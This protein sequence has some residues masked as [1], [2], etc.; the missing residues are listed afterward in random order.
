LFLFPP[1]FDEGGRTAL[2]LCDDEEAR[3]VLKRAYSDQKQL[4][5][6]RWGITGFFWS[7]F[8][9]FLVFFKKQLMVE[10]WGI[11]AFF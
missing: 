9:L 10:R 3:K 5:V 6:E 7:F 11:T 8:A 1:F 2:D 4:R